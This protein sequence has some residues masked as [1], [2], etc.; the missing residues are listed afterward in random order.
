MERGRE[1]DGGREVGRRNSE[2]RR[3]WKRLLLPCPDTP[4]SL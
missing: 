2:K 3:E 4:A 1:K